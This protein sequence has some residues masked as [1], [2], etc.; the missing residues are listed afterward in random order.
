MILGAS[1]PL[2][3][4][5]TRATRET[6]RSF[7]ARNASDVASHHWEIVINKVVMWHWPCRCRRA[8]RLGRQALSS[9]PLYALQQ[10]EPQII[11]DQLDRRWG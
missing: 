3:A 1:A 10:G 11:H 2:T 7:H 6:V 8:R 9:T 4:D 5:L